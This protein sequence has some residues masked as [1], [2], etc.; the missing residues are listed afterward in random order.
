MRSIVRFLAVGPLSPLG[1]VAILP[2]LLHAQESGGQRPQ[3]RVSVEMVSLSVAVF[4]EKRRLVTDLEAENFNIYEDGVPQEIRIFSREALPLRMAILL[5]TSSSIES[6]L[7]LAQE[8]AVRFVDSLQLGDQ[9]KIV[10]FNTR[11]LSLTDYTPDFR[12]AKEA[13]R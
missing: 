4:D 13:I 2:G 12:E 11:V 6:R 1:L 8:A 7:A 9:V 5:D 10:E 3:F